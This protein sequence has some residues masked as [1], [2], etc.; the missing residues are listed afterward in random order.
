MR[1][2]ASKNPAVGAILSACARRVKERSC[3]VGPFWL[4]LPEG[5]RNRLRQA[6]RLALFAGH[7]SVK[8]L[9]LWRLVAL[10]G[11]NILGFQ[12]AQVPGEIRSQPIWP[13]LSLAQRAGTMETNETNSDR[14]VGR[15]FKTGRP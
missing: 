14:R 7:F 2:Q 12:L 11:E 9:I 6:L 13:M 1:L 10:F 3:G 8:L 4:C 5:A 15:T